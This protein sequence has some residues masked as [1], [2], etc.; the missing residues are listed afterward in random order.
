MVLLSHAPGQGSPWGCCAQSGGLWQTSGPHPHRQLPGA[1]LYFHCNS[2]VSPLIFPLPAAGGTLWELRGHPHNCAFHLSHPVGP[3]E[4]CS[5]MG[6][7]PPMGAPSSPAGP[8]DSSSWM[9]VPGWEFCWGLRPPRAAPN[10]ILCHPLPGLGARGCHTPFTP[11][12]N[13]VLGPLDAECPLGTLLRCREGTRGVLGRWSCCHP[14][15][16]DTTPRLRGFS[17]LF[18]PFQGLY[19]LSGRDSQAPLALS[20]SQELVSSTQR[21]S[22]HVPS[23]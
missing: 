11:S 3:P 15:P 1:R 17:V 16:A 22:R 9:G 7:Q 21:T 13:P 12:P 14:L 19:S 5:A 4:P 6:T 8:G 20:L 10:P 23:C 18:C 2:I